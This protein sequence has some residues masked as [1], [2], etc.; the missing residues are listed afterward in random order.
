MSAL[1]MLER[2]SDEEFDFENSEYTPQQ[3]LLSWN[4]LPVLYYRPL[5]P[6][7]LDHGYYSSRL[8]IAPPVTGWGRL[9]Y[10]P[11]EL[12]SMVL[13]RST[14]GTLLNIILVNR[15]ALEFMLVL[16][17]FDRVLATLLGFIDTLVF[18]YV[19]H[20][21]YNFLDALKSQTYA[22]LRVL[23]KAPHAWL[24]SLPWIFTTDRPPL[25]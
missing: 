14:L 5:P 1:G 20:I 7:S 24:K 15:G 17:N 8:Q 2:G 18:Q 23:T 16:P 25:V 22:Y 3:F 21:R 9:A 19:P 4:L 11:N 10:L 6:P 13:E 12:I